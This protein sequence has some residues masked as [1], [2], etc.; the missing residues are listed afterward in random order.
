VALSVE[1]TS[2]FNTL[3]RQLTAT[4][5]DDDRFDGYYEG[6]QRLEHIGLAVP[7]E[8]RRFETVVNWPRVTV[9][10][11][12]ERLDVKSLMLPGADTADAGL[13][14]GWDANNLDSES[15]LVHLDTMVY[16]R[17]FVSVGTNEADTE[18]PLISVES[19]RQVTCTVDPRTKR[20]TSALKVY[21]P[22]EQGNPQY[23]T[24]YLP[25]RT[26][27]LARGSD[28]RWS[29]YDRDQHNLGRVPVVMFLNRRRT[30]L[31]TGAS[32]MADVIPLTDAAARALTNLQIAGETHS[33]PQ[34]WVLGMTKGDFVDAD[35]NPIPAWQSYFSAI[36]ANQKDTAKVGQFQAS[37]L[38]N[39]HS[40]VNHYA[41]LVAGLTGLPL[42]YLGQNSANPPSA[43]GIR[44]DE[45]RLVKRA[46]RKQR[47]FGDQ[48]G[49]VFALYLRFRD[50][51]NVDGNRIKVEWY[52]A[53]TPTY[54]QKVDGI[55]KLTGG[56]PIL[57]REGGW[58]E[59]GWSEARKDRE[60]A[61]F[62]NVANDPGLDALAAK[63]ISGTGNA[64]AAGQ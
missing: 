41:G 53:A 16:G 17:G 2:L 15:S 26:V 14:E 29:D 40:T 49:W 18:H 22:D 46:E 8:L 51:E 59:L 28:G 7:P 12:E 56:A 6:R 1:E 10:A 23:A 54:A 63:L 27:W 19:P 60:R 61:Y 36:W 25:D 4:T 20:L 30:G 55:Q 42:R 50:G 62:D 37:D 21:G 31:W 24:L 5:F 48:W 9:D 35:G 3:G 64:A 57:S 34:K 32:E 11:L 38:S 43:D 58:D 47:A 44:A 39:F 13:Q 52:D 45:A 33:V